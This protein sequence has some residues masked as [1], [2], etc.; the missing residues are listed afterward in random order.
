MCGGFVYRQVGRPTISSIGIFV[1]IF[2]SGMGLKTKRMMSEGQ[3]RGEAKK[4]R[5]L[6]EGAIPTCKY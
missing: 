1:I 2:S 3:D 4:S 5:Q 6:L